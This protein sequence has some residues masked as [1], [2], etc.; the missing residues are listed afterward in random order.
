MGG[1]VSRRTCRS[2]QGEQPESQGSGRRAGSSTFTKRSR[3][4]TSLRLGTCRATSDHFRPSA[5]TACAPRRMLLHTGCRFLHRLP[6]HRT[7]QL[8][9]LHN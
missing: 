1:R 3:H 9:G 8:S 2:S 6:T 7:N 4:C 5:L